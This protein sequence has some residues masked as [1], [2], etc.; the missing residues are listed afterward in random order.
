MRDKFVTLLMPALLFFTNCILPFNDKL[1]LLISFVPNKLKFELQISVDSNICTY[2]HGYILSNI[3]FKYIL[4]L[5]YLL[6]EIIL[7]NWQFL[8][9]EMVVNL[10]NG[11]N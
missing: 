2:S 11:Q 6:N 1:F 5:G 8:I 7:I 3:Y 9:S 10:N 4:N